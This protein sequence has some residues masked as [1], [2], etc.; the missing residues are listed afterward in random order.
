M[1]HRLAPYLWERFLCRMA[2][3]AKVRSGAGDIC[4]AVRP[5]DRVMHR[6]SPRLRPPARR[7]GVPLSP[8]RFRKRSLCTVT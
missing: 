1:N 4:R 3:K 6:W 5:F 2:A 8:A 7:D